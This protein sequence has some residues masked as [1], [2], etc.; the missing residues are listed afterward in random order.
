MSKT[1]DTKQRLIETTRRLIQERAT[2][3]IKDIAQAAY[4]NV[5]AVN[6]Y[7]GDKNQLIETVVQGILQ[8][9]KQSLFTAIRTIPLGQAPATTLAGMIDLLY[10]FALENIGV[11]NYLFL[12]FDTEKKS[13]T[14][15]LHEFLEDEEFTTLVLSMLQIQSGIDDQATLYARYMLIFSSFCI[16]LFIEIMRHVNPDTPLKAASLRDNAFRE[17]YITEL[18]RI[19]G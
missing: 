16:P 13:S 1:S 15:L 10:Q 5:A 11:I 8:D 17:R 3:T 19:I 2:F 12:D 7:F 14:L 4:V 18:L 6:Y 9:F